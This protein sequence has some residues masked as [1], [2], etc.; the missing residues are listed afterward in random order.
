M[1][2]INRII[3]IGNYGNYKNDN[4]GSSRFVTL[5]NL[6]L[7][8]SY[9]T[10]V[11]FEDGFKTI[12]RVNDWGNTTGRHL[13][14]IDNGNKADRVVSEKFEELLKMVLIK[15]NLVNVKEEVLKSL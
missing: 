13:N 6:T 9:K 3:T 10:I 12:V 5:G 8:F 11:A 15:H 7:Y 2:N 1:E 4:Y 14:C